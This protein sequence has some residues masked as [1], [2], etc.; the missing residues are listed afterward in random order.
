MWDGWLFMNVRLMAAQKEHFCV[1]SFGFSG[2]WLP[3]S[4]SVIVRKESPEQIAISKLFDD[5]AQSGLS[6]AMICMDKAKTAKI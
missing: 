4:S 5:D 2:C 3:F 1:R 6:C